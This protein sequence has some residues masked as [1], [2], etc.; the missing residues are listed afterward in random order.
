ME[1]EIIELRKQ[2]LAK[3]KVCINCGESIIHTNKRGP[4]SKYCSTE[5]RREYDKQTKR[6]RAENKEYKNICEYCNIEFN[7]RHKTT[8][9][10]SDECRKNK[11]IQ[12]ITLRRTKICKY[13]GEQFIYKNIKQVYCSNNCATEANKLIVKEKSKRDFIEKINTKFENKIKLIS[14]YENNKSICE[15]SCNECNFKFS[16]SADRILRK[17]FDDCPNCKGN[18]NK[19]KCKFCS[20]ELGY[21]YNGNLYGEDKKFCSKACEKKYYTKKCINCNKEFFSLYNTKTCSNICKEEI[22]QKNNRLKFRPKEKECK[23]CGNK[24]ITEFGK[25]GI[26][27]CSDKCRRKMN[28]KLSYRKDEREKVMRRNGKYDNTI[29]LS[30]LYKKSNGIC[31]ICGNMCDYNDYKETEEGYFISGKNYPSID[32]IIP[33]TKGGTHTW[34]NVQLAHMICNSLKRDKLI[35]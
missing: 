7:A 29:T 13:C 8:K 23:Y 20:K 18:V 9:Y 2:N 5:C 24:F 32:H 26:E 25:S 34:D 1:P 14:E 4:Y 3:T 10:C 28:N 33:V 19:Y 17:T 12:E 6:Q 31:S 16:I 22:K 30:K 15:F 35:E 21:S 11:K 27:Y